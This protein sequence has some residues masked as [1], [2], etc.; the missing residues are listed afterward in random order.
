MRILAIET[1][2]AAC[3][4]AV[5]RGD[6]VLSE[7]TLQ[8]PRAHSTWLMPLVDQAVRASGVARQDL[9]LIAAGT[10]P[11]SFTGLRIGLSTAKALAFALGK[12][13]VGVPT[14]KALAYGTGAQ[15]GIVVPMLDARRGEVYTGIYVAG[16]RD[17]ATWGEILPPAHMPVEHLAEQILFLRNALR[18]SWQFITLCGD[19]A[20]RYMDQMELGEPARLAPAGAMLPRGWAVAALARATA[21]AGGHS[22]D[23]EALTPVYLRKSEAETLWE[24]RKSPSS[25]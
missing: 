21:V 1:A 9:D 13:V 4:V 19:A 25:P 5:T 15:M 24:A 16:T 3:T 10:G 11:G 22:Q 12:P 18:H 23:P 14:L 20:A 8:V 6:E 7:L 2:T 17:P